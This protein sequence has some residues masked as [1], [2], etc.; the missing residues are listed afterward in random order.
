MGPIGVD[1]SGV[2]LLA[3]GDLNG[4]D[5]LKTESHT[6]DKCAGH[7][8]PTLMIPF[9]GNVDFGGQYHHHGM[10]GDNDPKGHASDRNLDF[11]TYCSG[12]VNWYGLSQENGTHSPL[13]GFMADGIPIYGPAGMNG[14]APGD[15]D[16]CNGHT[17]DGL[18][19][20]HYHVTSDYPYLVDCLA[21]CTNGEFSADL[22]DGDSCSESST[23]YNYSSLESLTVDYGGGGKNNQED[24]VRPVCL[25]VF[26]IFIFISAIAACCVLDGR[27]RRQ[28]SPRPQNEYYTTYEMGTMKP[29]A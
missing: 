18:G 3:A 5:A 24:L 29:T 1:L 19:F 8:S 22:D 9:L 10:P 11:G 16:D 15:L 28:S 23:Q 21:G 7:N 12:V 6:F 2:A 17:D 26:G 20:Y 13:L 27:A 14:T 25:L 4:D